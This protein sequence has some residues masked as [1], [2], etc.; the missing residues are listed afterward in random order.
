MLA[1]GSDFQFPQTT[2]PKPTGTDLI[3]K[4]MARLFQKA[5]TDNKVAEAFYKVTI[6][7]DRPT[8]LF[9]PNIMWRV[10][11]PPLPFDS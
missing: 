1:A 11:L 6:M 3:N 2:G 8:L 4:Y 9:R 5:Q 10:L 7:E